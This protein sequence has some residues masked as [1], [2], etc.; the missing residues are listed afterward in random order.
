MDNILL[1]LFTSRVRL[2][3][4]QLFLANSTEMYYVRQV[5]RKGSEEVNAV[6]RELQNMKAI[7]LLSTEERGNRLYY[8]LRPDFPFL[9]EFY[10]LVAK[11]TNLGARILRER[12]KLGQ[13]RYAALSRA[14]VEGREPRSQDVDLLVVGQVEVSRLQSMVREAEGEHGHEIN[15][16]VLTEDELNFRKKRNDAFMRDVLLQPLVM[17]IGNERELKKW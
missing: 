16:T 4:L 14:F 7:G 8:K 5:T 2:K 3:L 1:Q 12:D 17:L 11:T 15:Y 9:P 6:R 10:G 13:V